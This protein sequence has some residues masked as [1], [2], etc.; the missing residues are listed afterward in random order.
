MP[1]EYWRDRDAV[2]SLLKQAQV[3]LAYLYNCSGLSSSSVT[4]RCCKIEWNS[5][6]TPT[7]KRPVSPKP[8][9][10]LQRVFMAPMFPQKLYKFTF[11][12]YFGLIRWH[13]LVTSQRPK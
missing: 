5:I 9:A 2:N 7:L 1:H 12:F 10:K 4:E 3:P 6:D 8:S 13:T 11:K